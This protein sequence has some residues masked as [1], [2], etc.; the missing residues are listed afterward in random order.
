[1]VGF[2]FAA[3]DNFG[4]PW[5]LEIVT[6][7]VLL[8]FIVRKFPGPIVKQMMNN[9]QEQIR[10]SLAAG[11]EAKAEIEAILAQRQAELDAAHTESSTILDQAR[12]SAEQVVAD[13]DRRADEEYERLVQSAHASV[14]TERARVRDEIAT[15]LGTVVIEAAR[16]VIDA[17]LDPANHRRLIGEAI[18]AAETG[19]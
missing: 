7:P 9:R 11:E 16:E 8:W 14:E 2:V 15:A 10:S 4:L 17:E 13:G 12:R 1:M 6:V 18:S 5:L 19:S 3:G